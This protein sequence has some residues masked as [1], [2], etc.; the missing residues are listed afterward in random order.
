MTKTKRTIHTLAIA[1]TLILMTFN[2]NVHADNKTPPQDAVIKL[3][4]EGQ[5]LYYTDIKEAITKVNALTTGTTTS[6][7]SKTSKHWVQ[8]QIDSESTRT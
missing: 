8:K 7:S 1:L 6:S 4:T 3:I 5:T 2:T